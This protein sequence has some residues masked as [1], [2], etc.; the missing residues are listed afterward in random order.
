MKLINKTYKMYDYIIIS[1]KISKINTIGMAFLKTLSAC[2]ASI[3][4]LVTSSFINNLISQN[5]I[6]NIKLNFLALLITIG[7]NWLTNAMYKFIHLKLL[8]KINETLTITITEKKGALAYS[9]IE[10]PETWELMERIGDD[11]SERWI[12]GIN[13]ILDLLV[14]VIQALGLLII[15]G[16]KNYIIASIILALLIPFFFISIKN[17]QEDYDAFETSSEYFRRAKY[18]RKLISSRDNVEERTLFQYNEFIN[19]KWSNQFLK[20]IKVEMLAN[21]KIFSRVHIGNIGILFITSLIT[22]I[23]VIPVKQ[24]EMS[25]GLFIALIKGITSFITSISWKFALVMMELEK[26]RLYL[27]DVTAFSQL[28]EEQGI[29]NLTASMGQEE[30]LNSIEF[31]NVSFCYPGTNKKI[32]DNFTVILDGLKKYAFV[33]LNGAGKTTIIKLLTGL[34]DNYTGIIR[35]NQKDIRDIEKPKLKAYFSIVYQDFAR[36]EISIRENI[37]LSYYGKGLFKEASN[38][39]LETIMK[40]LGMDNLLI[41]L[42]NGIDTKVGKLEEGSIDLSGGEWQKIAILRS[43]VNNAPIYILDEPTAALDPV[44]EY[45]LYKIFYEII[46]EKFAIFITHRL[47]A[48]RIADEIIVINN[49]TIEEQGSH[50]ELMKKNGLYASM[51]ETQRSWYNE[52]N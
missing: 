22:F 25:T 15:I 50:L 42:K 48:A 27:K 10:N 3:M 21:R 8:L 28:N 46:K 41:N 31:I 9:Y 24:G 37:I 43:L 32:L 45:E 36:Y 20:A 11:P 35:I 52:G 4:V 5:S 44:S 47:G 51:F 29:T 38:I 34:Y 40:N 19:R 6:K 23:L 30:T 7:L 26:S 2:L 16:S 13:N 39:Q 12:K 17:G 33:G 18:F 14:F 1:Y 49:G